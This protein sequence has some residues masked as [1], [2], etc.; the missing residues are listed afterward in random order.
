MLDIDLKLMNY[1]YS[2]SDY[3]NYEKLKN[4]EKGVQQKERFF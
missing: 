4:D 3:W 2:E 1:K